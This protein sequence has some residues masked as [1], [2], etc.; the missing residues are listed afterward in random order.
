MIEFLVFGL[1]W[2]SLFLFALVFR[3]N[4]I[5]GSVFLITQFFFVALGVLLWPFIKGAAI[6]SAPTYNLKLT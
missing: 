5:V 2:L 3:T 1:C 6:A 4:D